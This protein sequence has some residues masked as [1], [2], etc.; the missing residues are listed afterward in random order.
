MDF[1]SVFDIVKA[2]ISLF[3]RPSILTLNSLLKIAFVSL[4]FD[5]NSIVFNNNL[6]NNNLEE[7]GILES[8]SSMPIEL[9]ITVVSFAV[10]Y[11]LSSS[12]SLE[13]IPKSLLTASDLYPKA[14]FSSYSFY[15]RNS[16]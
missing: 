1:T 6:R 4:T 10:K 15:S 2:V 8:P 13:T 16:G 9:T 12:S 3:L 5:H 11:L 7:L 14:S